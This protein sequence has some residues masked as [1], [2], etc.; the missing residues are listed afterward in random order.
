MSKL[1]LLKPFV[2]FLNPLAI[3]FSLHAGWAVAAELPTEKIVAVKR[4]TVMQAVTVDGLIEATRQAA[5]AAQVPGRVLEVRV[6]AGQ[7]VKKGDILMRLDTREANENVAGTEAQWVNA[8]ANLER[9]QRLQ[10]QKFVS[11][12]AVD[13]AK[14]DF[15]SAS[16]NRGAAL[17]GQSHG[18]IQAPFDGWIALRSANLGDLVMPGTP[19]V[20]VYDPSGLRAVANVPQYRVAQVKQAKLAKVEVSDIANV[21]RWIESA[22]ITVVPAADA[23]THATQVRVN[24]PAGPKDIVP[25]SYARVHFVAGSVEKL[26]VPAKAVLRRGEVAAVYVQTLQGKLSLRQLRLGEKLL[27]ANTDAYEVLAGLADGDQVVTDPV[28]AAMSLKSSAAK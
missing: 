1:G 3:I 4:H 13:K 2:S 5:I 15:D 18:V 20:T 27:D 21:N 19:L 17:A 22:A 12:A 23:A 28:Q 7:A 25:G 26:T 14:A 8:K 9:T 16:A 24:L 11:Q 10:Q 6:E